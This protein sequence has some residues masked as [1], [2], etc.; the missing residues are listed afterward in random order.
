MRHYCFTKPWYYK[1]KTFHH[2][3]SCPSAGPNHNHGCTTNLYSPNSVPSTSASCP[4]S[5]AYC[6]PTILIIYTQYSL[7][8]NS[9]HGSARTPGPLFLPGTS[10][11]KSGQLTRDVQPP[12]QQVKH[13]R[14]T[15]CSTSVRRSSRHTSPLQ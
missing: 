14:R 10:D 8:V 3:I 15:L 2:H 11:R 6:L 7:S 5:P 4:Q 13:V 9:Q 1:V 12:V